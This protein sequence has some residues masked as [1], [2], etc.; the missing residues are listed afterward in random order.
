MTRLKASILVTL[1]LLSGAGLNAQQTAQ[2]LIRE[3]SYLLYLPQGYAADTAKKWPL[4]MFLHGSGERGSDVQQVKKHGPPMLADQGKQ[5]PFILISP[6]APEGSGWQKDALKDLLADVQKKYRVDA[7]RV[8]LTGLSMGGYGTWDL[9]MSEPW[10][11]AAIAPICGGGDASKAWRLKNVPVWC[12][13]GGKDYVVPLSASQVMVDAVKPFNP[14]VKFTVYPEV[15]HDSWI[16]A[17]NNDSLYTWLLSHKRYQHQHVQVP[18]AAAVL[19]S[20][21]GAYAGQG[22]DTVTIA[23]I[24]GKLMAR[25]PKGNMELKPSSETVFFFNEKAFDYVEFIRKPDG[26]V[27]EFM[28]MTDKRVPFR[29]I[30]K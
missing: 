3:T 21:E 18:V 15:G 25:P 29:R 13:H 6:Q 24:D 5:F 12:F 23:F 20:Y 19:K 10:L 17:Y 9:A 26:S 8:Y 22:T 27:N 16:P 30:K 28:L 11:F 14:G 7:D 4:V 1:V 2:K